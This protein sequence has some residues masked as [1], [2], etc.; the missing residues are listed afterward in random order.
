MLNETIFNYEEERQEA[1]ACHNIALWYKMFKEE[2]EQKARQEYW[3]N[4]FLEDD[5]TR[6]TQGF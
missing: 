5:M 1:L 3:H 4:K 2:Q 6:C